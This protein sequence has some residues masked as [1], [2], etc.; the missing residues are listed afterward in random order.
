M[1]FVAGPV[2]NLPG[3]W[4]LDALTGI[5]KSK[6]SNASALAQMLL[7][8][9]IMFALVEVPIVA[10]SSTRTKRPASSTTSRIG[11]TATPAR[12]GSWSPWGGSVAPHE[13]D[14]RPSEMTPVS[15]GL[16]LSPMAGA[17]GHHGR[18]MPWRWRRSGWVA[19]AG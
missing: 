4:Y 14:R 9:V 8:N 5:A 16:A 18:L 6:A 15:C 10:T 17:L 19:R 11:L 2:L 12:S 7:F 3:I 1:A 13:R